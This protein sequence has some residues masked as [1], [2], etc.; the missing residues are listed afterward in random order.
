LRINSVFLLAMV[1]AGCTAASANSYDSADPV[2]CVAIF[3]VTSA[4]AGSSLLG[5]ELRARS[6]YITRANGGAEWLRTVTPRSQALAQQWE[7]SGDQEGA[8]RLFE[9]CRDRQDADA[10]FR[11]AL[12]SLLREANRGQRR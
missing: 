2:Q 5:H 6:L 1:A 12:P 9:E 4:E 8:L 11:A 7:S 10:N 3:G